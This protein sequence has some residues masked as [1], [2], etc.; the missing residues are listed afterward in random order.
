MHVRQQIL[1]FTFAVGLICG[2]MPT[3]SFGTGVTC[4]D[5][6]RAPTLPTELTAKLIEQ[7][8]KTPDKRYLITRLNHDIPVIGTFAGSETQNGVFLIRIRNRAQR[9]RYESAPSK[10][11]ADAALGS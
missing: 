10:G 1:T 4:E 8:E 11:A 5:V 7:L 9:T 3:R 2:L 6:F